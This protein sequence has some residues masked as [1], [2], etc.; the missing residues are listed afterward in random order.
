MSGSLTNPGA[1]TWN[2]N[3]TI[4]NLQ[5]VVGS[6]GGGGGGGVQ[7]VTGSTSISVTG[8]AQNPVL[9]VAGTIVTNPLTTNLIA[10]NLQIT[11]VSTMA[12]NNL[13]CAM[14]TTDTFL[15]QN[16][17][18]TN[19]IGADYNNNLQLGDPTHTPAPLVKVTAPTVTYPATT[20]SNQV[21][22]TDYVRTALASIPSGGV[23]QI[24]AGTGVTISPTGGTG[25]V[26][27]NANPASGFV[28]NPMTSDLNAGLFSITNAKELIVQAPAGNNVDIKPMFVTLTGISGDTQT[29]TTKTNTLTNSIGTVVN[30]ITMDTSVPPKVN[31]H[32]VPSGGGFTDTTMND[33]SVV[34]SNSLGTSAGF[35]AGIGTATYTQ[36][37]T[38]GGNN[39]I[40]MTTDGTVGKIVLTKPAFAN[41]PITT[42]STTLQIQD[43]TTTPYNYSRMTATNV[44]LTNQTGLLATLGTSSLGFTNSTS[45]NTL[46]LASGPGT[47]S[48]SDGSHSANYGASSLNINDP[49]NSY[50][51]ALSA[52]VLRMQSTT[53]P[54]TQTSITQSGL[55]STN[56][57]Q[58]ATASLTTSGTD[59]TLT[60]SNGTGQTFTL[61][62]AGIPGGGVSQIV[63]GTGVTIS[64]TGG[65]GIVTINASGGGGVTNPM[66]SNLNA[67]A[68]NINNLSS[69]VVGVPSTGTATSIA[70]TNT[71]ISNTSGSTSL[72][73]TNNSVNLTDTSNPSQTSTYILAPQVSGTGN[74]WNTNIS[75]AFRQWIQSSGDMTWNYSPAGLLSNRG[76]ISYDDVT[77]Q[78]FAANLSS[79]LT[80]STF[81]LTNVGAPAALTRNTQTN[82]QIVLTSPLG[83]GGQ[84]NIHTLTS[85]G[86]TLTSSSNDYTST[87]SPATLIFTTAPASGGGPAQ[88]AQLARGSLLI[89]SEGSGVNGAQ[90]QLGLPIG[91]P[92]NGV[93]NGLALL[94]SGTAGFGNAIFNIRNYPVGITGAFAESYMDTDYLRILNVSG[95]YARLNSTG[96]LTLDNGAGQSF[97]LTSAG[98]TGFVTN[99][100]SASLN[101]N[102]NT[103][104]NVNTLTMVNNGTIN[105]NDGG[106]NSVL[107]NGSSI[108]FA[109]NTGQNGYVNGASAKWQY[110]NVGGVFGGTTT[111]STGSGV[112]D[113]HISAGTSQAYCNTDVIGTNAT[114]TLASPAGS[115][116]TIT[117]SSITQTATPTTSVLSSSVFSLTNSSSVENV[118][119]NSGQLVWSQNLATSN[120]RMLQMNYAGMYFS[121]QGAG[122]NQYLYGIFSGTAGTTVAPRIELS[123]VNA[124][125]SSYIYQ[126]LL[127]NTAGTQPTP[128]QTIG[129]GTA[130]TTK[131][132]QNTI[133]LTNTGTNNI[134]TLDNSN[135]GGNEIRLNY[136]TTGVS[137]LFAGPSGGTVVCTDGSLG[138]YTNMLYNQVGSF[139]AQTTATQYQASMSSTAT[140][141][142]L[143]VSVT[144]TVTSSSVTSA[145]STGVSHTLTSASGLTNAQ[146]GAQITLTNSGSNTTNV[147]NAG[148][149]I[150]TN[151][152][153][154]SSNILV[155]T[156]IAV[157][158]AANNSS[159]T[160]STLT[161]RN[162]AGTTS[163]VATSAG[164]GQY[165]STTGTVIITSATPNI[166]VR[167]STGQ[168]TTLSSNSVTCNTGN[169]TIQALTGYL[170]LTGL[171]TSAVGLPA[172]AVWRNGTVLNIV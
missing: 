165:T 159:L 150:L 130:V 127:T 73:L 32:T 153:T 12:C 137:R 59:A 108:R 44:E 3:L 111:L 26:T 56:A 110:A 46:T 48:A 126:D 158:T 42:L 113:L 145:T 22:T 38:T 76:H 98:I 148:T 43:G 99:P 14:G 40:T 85:T 135:A 78:D 80:P 28:T 35:T 163:Y 23:T 16:Q 147:Q 7:S 152:G 55:S 114:I 1:G 161:V 129:V 166:V 115:T 168:A 13:L 6:G 24:V 60:L 29:L 124:G 27:V 128:T 118:G 41:P 82:S 17:L 39:S 19:Y 70:P 140:S 52:G 119:L 167:G 116:N 133:I 74:T 131:L 139:S 146:T 171:P 53:N 94:G 36:R 49:T 5:A 8:T 33:S 143:N 81:Q 75:G 71:V 66:T 170:L 15:L 121:E 134:M 45:G 77:F 79:T 57:T 84:S 11:G 4:N 31:V 103:I 63:A 144:G 67:G 155:P 68:F 122:F 18:G 2:Q 58:N 30:T 136:G 21:A 164:V 10:N 112:A 65:T 86:L 138:N 25:V 61:T 47:L 154:S 92:V 93:N 87:L 120:Q 62:S 83:T 125:V 123:A 162:A 149:V 64:P 141:A 156:S 105:T 20:G 157:T 117:Q 102:N 97:T 95:S 50:T 106:G 90:A 160:A 132:T 69:V 101:A 72:T 34:T 151:S 172:G 107:V 91:T 109:G 88:Y 37:D 104:T 142:T 54:T 169:L 96:T 51:C 89:F 9:S 100:M